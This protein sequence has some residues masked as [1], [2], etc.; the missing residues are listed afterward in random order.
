MNS[1]SANSGLNSAL[2]CVFDDTSPTAITENNFGFVRMSA[3]RNQ[4]MTIRDAAGNERGVNVTSGN[5]LT[6]DASATTQPVSGTVTANQGGTWNITNV[7]GT[8]SLPT[9][10]STSANQPSNISQGASTAS[11]TGNLSMGLVTTGNPTYTTG[12]IN[13][14]SLDTSGALRVNVIAGS[15][16]GGTSS[17]FG[18]AFPSTGTAAGAEYLSTPP[19][20]TNGQMVALQ[21]NVSGA[22]KVDGSAVTQPVSGTFWQATQPVSGTFWQATQPVSGTITANQGGAPWS[23]NL[24]Q[25]NGVALGSPSNYGTSPGAVSVPGVNAFVTNT[26]AASQSGNWTSRIVGNAGGLLDFA[27]S[28]V[29]NPGSALVTGGQFLTTPPTMTNANVTPL[30]VDSNANLRVNTAPVLLAQTSWTSATSLNTVRDILSGGQLGYD[31]LVGQITQ[32]TTLTAGVVTFEESYDGG[33][34]YKTIPASRF[35]DPTTGAQLT[36]PYTFVASTQQ[37]WQVILS[38]ANYVRYRLSTQISGTGSVV[39][40]FGAQA[41][42]TAMQ[43]SQSTSANLKGQVDPLTAA[44]WGIGTSTQN[45]ASVANGVMALA[46]F[47]T[48]PTTI[49]SGNMSPLQL[50]ANGNLLVNLKAS[51]TQPMGGDVASGS[52]DSGNPLKIG[53]LAKTVNPTAVADGQRVNGTFDKQGKLI[54]VGAIRQLKGVQKTSITTTTE[55]TVVTAGGANVFNDVYAIVVTNKSATA[56]FVDFK[57]AT[58]GTTRLTLAAPASDTRGFTVPVDSAMVQAVA[59]NNWT[60]TVSSAVTSIEITMLYVAN[61]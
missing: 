14:M 20:L 49:T 26:V 10:A 28:N 11:Q 21:T 40:T 1:A 9:G 55:T 16:G 3:N 39:I 18:S 52:S 17:S 41:A 24:T 38:G 60:A 32:G 35:I 42:P 33:A 50:D 46:Q 56:V 58:A 22:L 47:N 6:V 19:T 43:V 54:A 12:T 2:A 30:Q 27:G 7:S 8:V 53:G 34:N 48:T 37:P 4:Y 31:V 13:G 51:I 44:S 29:G 23:Q 5:A 57:D 36:N 59:A 61:L 45:S 15:G 25:V